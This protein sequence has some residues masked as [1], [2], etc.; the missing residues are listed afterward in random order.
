VVSHRNSVLH[1]RD[2]QG[3]K[4]KEGQEL[5]AA[6]IQTQFSLGLDGLLPRDHHYIDR[7]LDH[8]NALP[9]ANRKAWLHGIQIAREL[10]LASKVKEM[11]SMRFFMLHWLS[12]A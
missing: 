7:G 2:A 4:L 5:T 6:A 1:E 11:E 12:Q 3:L 10:Y 8:I 9:V